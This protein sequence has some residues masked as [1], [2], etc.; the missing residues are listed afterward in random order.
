MNY[1]LR[2]SNFGT[3]VFVKG[4]RKSILGTFATAS[5]LSKSL[6]NTPVLSYQNAEIRS[7]KGIEHYNLNFAIDLEGLPTGQV[8]SMT[9]SRGEVLVGSVP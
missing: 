3:G 2:L 7:A 6:P 4:R 5:M 1:T 9:M 8:F